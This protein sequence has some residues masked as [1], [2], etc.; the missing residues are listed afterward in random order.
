MSNPK[1]VKKSI[2]SNKA[3]SS[4]GPPSFMA[5][6][7]AIP[8]SIRVELKEKGMDYRWVSYT[9]Y[10]KYGGVHERGWTAYKRAAPLTGTEAIMFGSGTDGIIRRGDNLLA[11]RP[12]AW[13]KE[14]KDWIRS[15]TR[16]KQNHSKAKEEELRQAA[17]E[18]GLD[19]VVGDF[20]DDGAET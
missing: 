16:A 12:L 14:H 6:M 9:K 13:T 11:V 15:Q 17:R 3:T 7:H 20:A 2:S 5:D 10:A 19:V 18:R 1:V 4:F 8:E